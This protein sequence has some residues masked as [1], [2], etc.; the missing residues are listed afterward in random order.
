M[1]STTTLR[2]LR[3]LSSILYGCLAPV[4]G[5]SSIMTTTGPFELS[6]FAAGVSV[7]GPIASVSARLRFVGGAGFVGDVAAICELV[8][9]IVSEVCGT[10][11]SAGPVVVVVSEACAVLLVG[12][13]AAPDGGNVFISTG[14]DDNSSWAFSARDPAIACCGLLCAAVDG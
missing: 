5:S 2:F 7:E 9:G 1:S 10:S 8:A 14:L 11:I 6:G 4:E 13:D 12:A 3:Y